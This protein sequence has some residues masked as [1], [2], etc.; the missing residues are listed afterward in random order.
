MK[1]HRILIVEDDPDIR[2]AL[3]EILG[4]EGYQID[5]A[6]NGREGLDYLAAAPELPELIMLDL[7][8]PVL[9]GFGFREGQRAHPQWADIPV[10]VMSADGNVAAKLERIGGICYLRKPLELMELLERVAAVFK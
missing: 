9:D 4:E 10:I 1:S 7:M 6:E 3:V 2:N 8:M 5:W